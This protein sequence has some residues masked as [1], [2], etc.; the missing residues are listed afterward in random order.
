MQLMD[1]RT[2]VFNL[3]YEYLHDLIN[4]TFTYIIYNTYIK[5]RIQNYD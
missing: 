2:Y 5:L 3:S 4:I 1:E